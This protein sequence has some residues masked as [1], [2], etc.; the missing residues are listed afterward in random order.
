MMSIMLRRRIL[1]LVLV[2]VLAGGATACSVPDPLRLWFRRARA[3]PAV[4][5]EAVQVAWCESRHDPGA[6]K[7][8]FAALFPIGRQ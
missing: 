4:Q 8:Q 6:S 3:S 1:R 2:L 7:G 5:E